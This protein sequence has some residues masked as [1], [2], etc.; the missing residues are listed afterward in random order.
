VVS[1]CTAAVVLP[2][3]PPALH[4]PQVPLKGTSM[5]VTTAGAR[6]ARHLPASTT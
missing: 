2:G 1:V 6:G 4:D 3:H 5:Y